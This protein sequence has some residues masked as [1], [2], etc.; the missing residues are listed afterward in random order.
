M[1]KINDQKKP[2]IV[3]FM[4]DQHRFECLGCHGHTVVKTPNIDRLAHGGVGISRDAIHSRQYACR[5]EYLFLQDNICI[6]MESWQI[7]LMLM[8]EA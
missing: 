6:R 3:V 5:R 7:T 1:A 2:N 4:T 8:S